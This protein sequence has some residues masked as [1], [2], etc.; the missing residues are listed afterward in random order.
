M[1]KA[2]RCEAP[3]HPSPEEEAVPQRVVGVE[4]EDM[5]AGSE[6]ASHDLREDG[7]DAGDLLLADHATGEDGAEDAQ[8]YE[9]V[10]TREPTRAVEEGEP[11]RG[12]APARRAVDLA[13]REHGH[14]AL[15]E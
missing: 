15:G 6:S 4:R 1:P 12:P 10:A 3:L 13:V 2:T 8:V 14:V 11:G 9:I 7:R 5:L